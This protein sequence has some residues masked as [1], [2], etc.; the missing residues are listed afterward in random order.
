MI[1]VLLVLI[2]LVF[3]ISYLFYKHRRSDIEILQ[4]DNEQI[5]ENLS[6]LLE[7]LQPVIIRG[8]SP[9][10]GFTQESLRKIPRLK[11]FAV[12]G[13]P[14]GDIL[15]QPRMLFDANGIPTLAQSGRQQLAKELSMS[16]WA[17]HTWLP[18]FSQST[19]FGSILGC[20]RVEANLGGIGMTRTTAKY[21]CLMPTEGK[22]TLSIL[23]K[24]SESF[25]PSNWQ[26]KYLGLLTVNDTP[27]VAELKYIDVVLRPGT[28]I[29]LPPHYIYSMEPIKDSAELFAFVTMEYHEP[30]TLL[31]KS[32]SQN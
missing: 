9:P 8:I 4:L 22:Y 30:T 6:E 32:F 26:Y 10:K 16:I 13:Q 12:G 28:T 23:S 24:D 18:I 17:D 11:D 19:W 27:L 25:L 31:V 15:E 29:C 20:M 21:T 7:E 1:E 14:L 3:L 2:F 5:S